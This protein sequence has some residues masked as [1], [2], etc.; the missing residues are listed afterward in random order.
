LDLGLTHIAFSVGDLDASI[1]FYSDFADMKV[2]HERREPKDGT[3][4]AWISDRTRPFVLVLIETPSPGALR[5][6]ISR[7]LS[8]LTRPVSHLGV[9]CESREEVDRL[10]EEARRGGV[11]VLAPKELGPP[12]GYFGLLRDPD[13]HF[14]ELSFGQDVGLAVHAGDAR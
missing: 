3:R 11:L 13:G 2:V 5:R 8:R 4:V 1:A 12:V 7:V 6:S 10:C 14:L 9:A